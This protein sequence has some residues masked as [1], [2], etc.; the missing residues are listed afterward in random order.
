MLFV[1]NDDPQILNGSE[2]CGSRA[3]DDALLA[4]SQRLPGCETLA[5]AQSGVKNG[6]VVAEGG[7]EA[8]DRL[9]GE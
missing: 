8:A 3:Y 1:Q 7:A 6:H 9:R 2:H 5:V 4:S